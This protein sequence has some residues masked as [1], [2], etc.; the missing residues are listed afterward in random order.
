MLESRY[1]SRR[2]DCKNEF[3]YKMAQVDLSHLKKKT[4]EYK[5]IYFIKNVLPE[6][7]IVNVW[8]TNFI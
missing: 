8:F 5:L 4:A 1:S 3:Y 2:V 7:T 6:V